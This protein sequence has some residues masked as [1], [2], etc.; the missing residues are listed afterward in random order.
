M[1][2]AYIPFPLIGMRG[3]RAERRSPVWCPRSFRDR[4]GRLPARQQGLKVRSGSASKM[5]RASRQR[6]PAHLRRLSTAPGPAFRCRLWPGGQAAPAGDSSLSGPGGYPDAARVPMLRTHEPAGAAPRPASRTPRE[7]P[8][9]WTRY[10]KSNRGSRAG[11]KGRDNSGAGEFELRYRARKSPLY[12]V[13]QPASC[14]LF[15]S[16]KSRLRPARS[17]G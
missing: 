7:T 13:A 4:G 16:H 8:L 17:S 10:V 1:R 2:P 5:R 15:F 11:D 6:A 9:Q 12:A 14:G 3:W